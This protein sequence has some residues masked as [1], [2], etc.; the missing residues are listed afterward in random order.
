MHR[1][2]VVYN[3]KEE[4]KYRNILEILDKRFV[5]AKIRIRDG[6]F[7]NEYNEMFSKSS[8]EYICTLDMAGFQLNTL[9]DYPAY[10][11]MPEKQMH[12][13]IDEDIIPLYAEEDFGLHLFLYVPDDAQKWRSRY[14]HIPNIDSYKRLEADEIGVI[15]D[16]DFNAEILHRL[17]DKF[18][19]EVEV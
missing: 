15:L 17:I 9:L 3:A 4:Y 12:I 6:G 14:P 19:N 13:I 11:V 5:T 16:S 18:L 2:L 7:P 8:S 1:M 10:D